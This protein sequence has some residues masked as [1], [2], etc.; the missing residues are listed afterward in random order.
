MKYARQAGAVNLLVIPLVLVTVLLLGVATVAFSF[1]NEAQDYKNNVAQK[2][3]VE[4]DKAREEV[5]I[6]KDKDFAEKEKFP[7][8]RY[9]GPSSF[10]ALRILY[11]KTWSAYVSEPRNN[12]NRP[13]EGYFAPGHVPTINDSLNTFAL[14]VIVEQKRY[15]AV[16]KGYEDE[17]KQGKISARPYQSPNVPNIV[18]TRLDGEVISKKQ[19]A[20]IVMPMR[21]KTLRMWTE[22]RDYVADFDNIVLPNFSFTP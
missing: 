22:S 8:N 9:D 7:Y 12:A 10:G 2:V 11:P 19:G 18:G 15:D 3:A 20:M 14:R 4:V 6:Q 16:L 5:S 13:V 17:V 21:D 1:Y